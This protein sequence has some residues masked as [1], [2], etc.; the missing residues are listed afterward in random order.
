MN[1]KYAF[2][3]IDAIY[4]LKFDEQRFY[5]KDKLFSIL[6]FINDYCVKEIVKNFEFSSRDSM[7]I[8]LF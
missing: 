4:S 7:E 2:M 1:S 3:I 6:K 8:M 5:I